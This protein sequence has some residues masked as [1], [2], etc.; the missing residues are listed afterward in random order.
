MGDMM[1][2]PLNNKTDFEVA[3]I[4]AVGRALCIAQNFES[5][6]RSLA[7]LLD[8]KEHQ[9]TSTDEVAFDELID[10]LSKRMLAGSIQQLDKHFVV[11]DAVSDILENG[12]NARNYIAHDSMK[13]LFDSQDIEER[14][15]QD[16]IVLRD[17]VKKLAIADGM[18][19]SWSWWVSERKVVNWESYT[20]ATQQW[21][22]NEFSPEDFEPM[23]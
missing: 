3:Y 20:N 19:A 18:M 8:V 16:I 7:I 17:K 21:V 23:G 6:C 22:F 10:K 9:K 5:N 4:E 15:S 1:F 12:K 11:P 2:F 14:L 13:T